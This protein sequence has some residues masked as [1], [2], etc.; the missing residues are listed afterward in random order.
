MAR[1]KKSTTKK[2]GNGANLGFEEML[3]RAAERIAEEAT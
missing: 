1:G 2:S 3:W